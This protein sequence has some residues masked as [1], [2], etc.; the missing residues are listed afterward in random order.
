MKNGLLAEIIQNKQQELTRALKQC[1]EAVEKTSPANPRSLATA[2]EKTKLAILA[3]I[4][5]KSPI[6]GRF[7][8]RQDLVTIARDYEKAGATALS[9]L[10]DQKY[11]GGSVA[12]LSR[13]R[14]SVSIPVLRKDFILHEYQIEKSLEAGADAVLLIA[15]ILSTKQ[16]DKLYTLAT[17]LKMEVVVEF[18][19]HQ[20]S[21]SVR[22]LNPPIV[23]VN[24]RDLKSM[25]IDLNHFEKMI[26]YL[27]SNSLKIA[28]SGLRTPQDLEYVYRLGYD[29]ALLGTC[30][31]ESPSPGRT[32]RHL[33]EGVR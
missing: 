6:K 27:P 7:N 11:F 4:K 20:Y 30:L 18:H 24:C 12:L 10:T 9:V 3:E 19:D 33:L 13:V 21:S 5:P 16:L 1:R 2:L 26:G 29:A 8:K 17:D 22:D 31:M 14:Q 28:E 23:G 15:D 25:T 32:L